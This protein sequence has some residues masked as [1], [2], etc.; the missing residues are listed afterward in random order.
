MKTRPALSSSME[1]PIDH[2]YVN[3]F[4]LEKFKTRL[5][6]TCTLGE[7]ESSCI[8]TGRKIHDILSSQSLPPAQCKG[9]ERKLPV[10]GFSKQR[11]KNSGLFRHFED[12]MRDWLLSSLNLIAARKGFQAGGHQEQRWHSGLA[13]TTHPSLSFRLNSGKAGKKPATTSCYLGWE[14]MCPTF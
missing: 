8:K 13:H 3:Q 14:R 7:C 6:G 10:T 5:G 4:L 2:Q 9:V 12:F 1:T 11:G